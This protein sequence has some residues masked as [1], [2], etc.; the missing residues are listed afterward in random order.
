[1]KLSLDTNI[2]R[3]ISNQNQ[4]ILEILSSA[5][6]I[7]LPFIVV[8]ELQSG[9]KNGNRFKENNRRLESFIQKNSIQILHSTAETIDIYSDI[10]THLRKIGKPIPTNDIWIAALTMEHGSRLL[11]LDKH[12]DLL[13][14]LRL[15]KV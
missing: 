11:T 5:T 12:F 14:G 15:V 1:M 2:F 9:F 6:E 3:A 7:L 4:L 10:T 8:A 13:S